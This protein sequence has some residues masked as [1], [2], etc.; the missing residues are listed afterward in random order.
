METW[1]HILGNDKVVMAKYG[2]AE[3]FPVPNS[4]QFAWAS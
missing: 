1:E 3:E 4:M 2:M